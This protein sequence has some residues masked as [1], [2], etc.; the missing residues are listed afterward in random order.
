MS[1]RS[2]PRSL[3]GDAGLQRA[4]IDDVRAGDALI[5]DAILRCPGRSGSP[6]ARTCRQNFDARPV[7]LAESDPFGASDDR[8]RPVALLFSIRADGRLRPSV[9]AYPVAFRR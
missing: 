7:R 8:R 6:A 5:D 4:D 9:Q 1:R 3:A 2:R